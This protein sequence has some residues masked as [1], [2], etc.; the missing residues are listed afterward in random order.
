[1]FLS[2]LRPARAVALGDQLVVVGDLVVQAVEPR[3]D[4]LK[5]LARLIALLDED[6]M[7]RLEGRVALVKEQHAL[8]ERLD[9][10]VR[11]RVC[12]AFLRRLREGSAGAGV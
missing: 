4:V 11:S 3:L 8:D 5:A 1:M 2:S 10:D 9:G 12:D 6:L 7:A